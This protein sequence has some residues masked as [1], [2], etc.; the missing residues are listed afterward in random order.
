MQTDASVFRTE[1]RL[2][3]SPDVQSINLLKHEAQVPVSD[4]LTMKEDTT[5]TQIVAR[6]LR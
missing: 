6:C 2:N 5:E 1:Q 4:T 3:I